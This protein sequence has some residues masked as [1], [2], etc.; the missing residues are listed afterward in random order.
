MSLARALTFTLRWEG[1]YVDNPADRGGPTACG[2]TLATARA[3][4]IDNDGDGDT[5]ILDL[6]RITQEQVEGIYRE[7]Y[8]RPLAVS[9]P[10]PL[11]MAVFDY[12]VHSGVTRATRYLQLLL[13][14]HADGIVGPLTLGAVSEVSDPLS[15]A[16]RL[17]DAREAFLKAIAVGDQVQFLRGWLRRVADLRRELRR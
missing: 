17:C 2:I 10:E 14:L 4:G 6:R 7:R 5:H 9:C 13:G 15:V 12:S 3:Y 11:D 16:L 1:G 8:W